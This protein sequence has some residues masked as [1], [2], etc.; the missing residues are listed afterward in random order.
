[1]FRS[2]RS[3]VLAAIIV[4]T[5]LAVLLITVIFYWKS[6]GMIEENY[7]ENLYA[8]LRQT[9]DSFDRSM[10]KMYHLT[11]QESCEEELIALTEEYIMSEDEQAMAEIVSLLRTYS[12]RD[13]DI[14]SV[15]LMINAH[16]MI[17]SSKEYPVYK[18][19]I[20]SSKLA[21]IAKIAETTLTP[22]FL[23]DPL[24]IAE[25]I[26]S[27]VSEVKNENGE[28]IGYIMNNVTEAALNYK[29][30]DGLEGNEEQR[31]ALIDRDGEIVTGTM[32]EESE[33]SEM[34]RENYRTEFSG[35]K[36]VVEMERSEVLS[37]LN[38]IRFFLVLILLMAFA[39]A[40]ICAVLITRVIYRPLKE[41]TRTMEEVSEG[42]LEQR[43]EVTTTDEIGTL[44]KEFNQMLDRI[45]GL[46][47]QLVQEEMLKKNAE[48]EAL[49]YQITP[50]FM[51]NTLN[52]IKYAALLK[53]ENEIGGLIE[54]FTELL[55][56][57]ISKKGT[58]VTVS[59]E[60]HFVQNYMNLQ[61]M[62]YEEKIRIDYR[63]SK[64]AAECFMPRL[65]MQP[66]VENAILHGLDLKNGNNRIVIG[67][68]VREDILYLWVQDNGRG[69]SEEQIE[70]ILKSG[71]KKTRG[72]SGIGV[73]NV[74][75]R[76]E[77]YY[78]AAGGISYQSGENGTRACIY[79]PAYKEREKYD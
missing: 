48:L 54:D 57:S 14:D 31:I 43:V 49:Q 62:R 78:G 38:S 42:E 33:N 25:N 27:Y 21:E 71:G 13:T 51:Y 58:F 4:I 18:S 41:L 28:I 76:L 55:Q 50:H 32:S 70:N 52:S 10:E 15:Y 45:E 2:M 63:V 20:E 16:R 24:R 61:N 11:V 53:G 46:I 64:E 66:L 65:M 3:K 7:K 75:E 67:S 30:L 69:L 22:A 60:I 23:S 56:A 39:V 26:L 35:Y 8:R 37:D 19:G 77:L 73:A 40:A 29:Y 47:E 12:K 17:M 79:L 44:S 72:L 9:G 36:F 74:R 59:E 34:I 5:T 6:S 1:M 68:E